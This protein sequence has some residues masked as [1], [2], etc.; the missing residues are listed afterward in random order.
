MTD[1][2]V[3]ALY[4]ALA[5]GNLYSEQSLSLYTA[6][7]NAVQAHFLLHRD[8]DYVVKSGAIESVDEFKG[9]IAQNRR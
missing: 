1:F 3:D 5:C 9:R 6:I 4:R 8:V 7:H 2:D